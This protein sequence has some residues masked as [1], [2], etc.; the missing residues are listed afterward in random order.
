[1][2]AQE[3][4]VVATSCLEEVVYITLL[5]EFAREEQ[6]NHVQE[7]FEALYDLKQASDCGK[8][9]SVSDCFDKPY[10]TKC[11]YF[12]RS[13]QVLESE[14]FNTIKLNR[15]KSNFAELI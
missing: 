6:P 9:K 1:M 4:F 3:H 5:I 8:V 11:F 12:A 10:Q 2:A 7:L 13:F 15:L 14:S